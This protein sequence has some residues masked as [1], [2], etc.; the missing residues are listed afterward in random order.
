[1]EGDFRKPTPVPPLSQNMSQCD[2]KHGNYSKR[3]Q[4]RIPCASLRPLL[5]HPEF[6]LLI[7]LLTASHIN[8]RK[9]LFIKT[10]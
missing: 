10:E 5:H 7:F 4:T 9:L 6:S 2:Q 3:I 8:L 1:M